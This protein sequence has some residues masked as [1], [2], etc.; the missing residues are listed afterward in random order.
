MIYP[1]PILAEAIK[2]PKHYRDV[3]RTLITREEDIPDWSAMTREE[4]AD[5]WETHEIAPNLMD[6]GEDVRAETYA[7]LGIPDPAKGRKEKRAG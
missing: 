1:Y 2:Q 4:E 7:A 5:W 6:S 3:E